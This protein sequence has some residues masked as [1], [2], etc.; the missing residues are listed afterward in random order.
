MLQ[1]RSPTRRRCTGCSARSATS[2]SRCSRS[3]T[4]AP[5]TSADASDHDHHPHRAPATA[6]TRPRDTDLARAD[7][8]GS[9]SS[10]LRARRR[11]DQ[12][13]LYRPSRPATTFMPARTP[14]TWASCRGRVW[15]SQHRQRHRLYSRAWG[16]PDS[17]RDCDDASPDGTGPPVSSPRPPRPGRGGLR[18]VVDAP[19]PDGGRDLA[20]CCTGHACCSGSRWACASS[21]ACGPSARVTSA[22]APG[23]DDP[24]LR[25]VA[26]RRRRRRSSPSASARRRSGPCAA[27]SARRRRRRLG[28]QPRPGRADHPRADCSSTLL[29]TPLL[30][31][32]VHRR[33]RRMADAR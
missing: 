9:C 10:S 3:P 14:T 17:P 28:H 16:V 23:L 11:R 15:S 32:H 1:G 12:L 24:R 8:P 26:P 13:R 27:V 2:A 20:R 19:L 31:Q 18:G 22:W 25:T 30:T 21:W 33:H 7:R 5:D 29:A 6:A 4:S